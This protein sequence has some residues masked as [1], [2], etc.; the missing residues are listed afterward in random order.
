[1]SYKVIIIVFTFKI[2]T[3][4]FSETSSS[5]WQKVRIRNLI[6]SYGSGSG[7]PIIDG[8]GT[9]VTSVVEP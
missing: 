1:M 7:W 3:E 9:L 5:L 4:H 6:Q 8:S 2:Y